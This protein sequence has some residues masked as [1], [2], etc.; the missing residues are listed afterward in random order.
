MSDKQRAAFDFSEILLRAIEKGSEG[1]YNLC[2]A[3]V[4]AFRRSKGDEAAQKVRKILW[5]MI[6]E[7]K[8]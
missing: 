1:D 4:E 3:I 7:S 6:Q 8:T 5:S 2:A